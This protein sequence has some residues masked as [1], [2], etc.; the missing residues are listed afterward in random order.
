MINS[1]INILILDQALRFF[2]IIDFPI[3]INKVLAKSRD[4]TIVLQRACLVFYLKA[5][6]LGVWEIARTLNMKSHASVIHLLKYGERENVFGKA[7][8]EI[9]DKISF[10]YIKDLLPIQIAY[11]KQEIRKLE[12]MMQRPEYKN[13]E[14]LTAYPQT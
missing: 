13:V 12:T 7:F 1:S 11:H 9:T 3:D 8:K 14:W 2:K 6:Q 10:N 5:H 4:E